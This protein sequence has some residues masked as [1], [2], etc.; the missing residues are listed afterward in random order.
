MRNQLI[1]L[2]MFICSAAPTWAQVGVHIGLPSIDIGIHLPLYPELMP[3]PGYPVY[4]APQLNSNYFF[5]DGMYWVF[6]DNN[7]YA[8]NWY[9]GPWRLVDQEVVPVFVLRIPVRYYRQSPVYFRGWSPDAA[10]HW[11][12][13]WGD[14]WQQRHHGWDKWNRSTP[15]VRPPLPVYQRNYTGDRYPQLREQQILQN[16]NYRYQPHDPLVRQQVQELRKHVTSMPTPIKPMPDQPRQQVSPQ[17]SPQEKNTGV[18]DVRE[19]HR[20]N[21]TQPAQ[22]Q[23]QAQREQVQEQNK[24]QQTMQVQRPENSQ[25]NQAAPQESNRA[26]MPERQQER[27]RPSERVKERGNDQGN[28]RNN[29]RDDERG[30][31]RKK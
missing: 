30:T 15:A 4:Y 6:Q 31:D 9:N 17:V 29:N 25:Q 8:S 3:V 11:G 12:E 10:P 21:P 20:A 28:E 26:Q 24:R 13:H 16:K 2:W 23:A 7:W 22:P 19:N 27:E 1:L 14:D 18:R 5:Y